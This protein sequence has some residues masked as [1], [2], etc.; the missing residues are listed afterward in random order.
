[1]LGLVL[2]GVN[3]LFG[4]E[5]L[6]RLDLRSAAFMVPWLGGL[7]LVSYLGNYPEQSVGAGNQAVFGTSGLA[8]VWAAL[9]ILL[10]SIVSYAMALALR[11]PTERVAEHIGG[12]APVQRR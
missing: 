8:L 3:V 11:L 5:R 4:R 10:L 12:V 6:P 2:Y 7:C 1:V 9:A